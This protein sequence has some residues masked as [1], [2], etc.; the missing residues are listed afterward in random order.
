[1]KHMD[2][3]VD[4]SVWQEGVTFRTNVVSRPPSWFK[5]PAAEEEETTVSFKETLAGNKTE[6]NAA[7][8]KNIPAAA[9]IPLIPTQS[10]H[11]QVQELPA[12]LADV[13]DLTP[14]IVSADSKPGTR[15]DH[16]LNRTTF[17]E[18]R[19][20]LYRTEALKNSKNASPYNMSAEAQAKKEP[21][22]L[23]GPGD[24]KIYTMDSVTRY[25][26][27]RA[28]PAFNVPKA[29]EDTSQQKLK[30]LEKTMLPPAT[31]TEIT[32]TA[33]IKKAPID[34]EAIRAKT[35]SDL[36]YQRES[37]PSMSSEKTSAAASWFPEAMTR[38]LDMYEAINKVNANAGM[39]E[40]RIDQA[41]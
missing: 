38:T 2:F 6:K 8:E 1:M 9:P 40:K 12:F 35:S 10:S 36:G 11:T 37:M 31:P 29:P 26:D 19:K 20:S 17:K 25:T 15:L 32:S 39:P 16:E 18:D 34:V 7:A 41:V 30:A 22:P 3:S 5:A 33:N 14:F 24:N 23:K 4:M 21:R 28:R 27:L 13:E